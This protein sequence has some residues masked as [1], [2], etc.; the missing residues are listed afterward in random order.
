MNYHVGRAGQQLGVYPEETIRDMLQRGELHPDDLGWREGQGEWQPLGQLFGPSSP[1]PLSSAG[2]RGFV[3]AH[4]PPPKP[5]NNLVPAILVTLFCCLPFGIASIVFASQVDSKYSGGDYAGA[6]ASL[7]KS[8]LWMWWAFG[9]G[10]VVS[11]IW[12]GLAF[13]GAMAGAA[14]GGR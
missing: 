10:L 12:F 9:V 8:K 5:K 14:N 1:P 11:V 4:L 13:V 6:E 2:T 7:A 3:K